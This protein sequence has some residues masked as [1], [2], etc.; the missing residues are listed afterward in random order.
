[1]KKEFLV[2][3][4]LILLISLNLL[5]IFV[6]SWFSS[7]GLPKLT[8]RAG[9]LGFISLF[10][11]DWRSIYLLNPENITYNFGV[12][13]N[14]TLDLEVSANFNPDTWWYDLIDKRHDLIVRQGNIFEPNTTFNAVRWNNL[15]KVYANSSEGKTFTKEVEFFVSVP[16]SAPHI[17]YID[18]EIFVCEGSDISYY[19][20]VTDVDEDTPVSSIVPTVPFYLFYSRA[21]NSTVKSYELFSGILRKSDLNG[22]NTGSITIEENISVTDGM[23]ADSRNTNITIIEINNAPTIENVGVQTIW[24]VGENTTFY[25]ELQANDLEDG[26]ISS[27]KFSL[28]IIALNSSGEEVDLFNVSQYGIIN[29]TANEA[30]LGGY[31]VSIFVTDLGL[32]N[33]HENIT[34]FCGETPYNKT[35][36]VN[37]TFTITDENRAPYI[38]SYYPVEPNLTFYEGDRIYFN[39]TMYDPDWNLLDSYW[40]FDNQMIRYNPWQVNGSFSELE[41]MLGYNTQGE[42][43]IRVRVTDG[44][45]DDSFNWSISVID[46]IPPAPPKGGGGGGSSI[47]VTCVEKWGCNSW[48]ECKN[49]KN[50]LEMAIL[51]ASDFQIIGEGCEEN[52]WNKDYCGFQI[53]QCSDVKYCNS[54]YDRPP[55][56]QA[57]YYTENPSCFDNIKNCHDESCE[58]LADCGG[59]C[60]PCPTCSDNIRNQGEEEVDC[61]GPCNPCSYDKPLIKTP[62]RYSLIVLTAL[63]LIVAIIISVRY[64]RF[65]GYL[66]RSSEY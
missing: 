50:S 52:S 53:R 31:N 51:S 28:S 45:L 15:L 8:G 38:A 66:A 34:S 65:K 22:P 42:H 16:N 7:S 59:P 37:F 3:A 33:Y 35:S 44:M 55:E 11:E 40:Y 21:I 56:I 29:F 17:N 64:F 26:D 10:I 46:K 1:M 12:G 23:Y 39:A 24:G 57:C 2:L 14:Y 32:Q 62:F 49:A 48:N 19:F 58:V 9:N 18:P 6:L 43:I 63:L 13:D 30:Q 27:G 61:G 20:N 5:N 41:H 36:E 47:A 4:V 60:K 25:Y 54:T